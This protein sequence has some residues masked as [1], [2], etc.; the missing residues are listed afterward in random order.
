MEEIRENKGLKG[1][2][3]AVIADEAHSS[4][5][6]QVAAKLKAVLTAEELAGDRG[7]RRDRRRGDPGCGGKRAGS[8]REHLLLRVHRHPQGQ[9][10]GA[11]R[12]RAAAERRSPVPFHVYSMKQAIEEGYIL[13]VLRGYHSFQMAFQ[14]AAERR[15]RR[16]GGPELRPPSAVMRWVKLNPQTIAQKSAI[17]V[18]HFRENVADLLEGHAKAMVVADSRKAAVRYKR[19]IDEYIAAQGLRHTG[20]WSR[21]PGRSATPS[22]GI[23]RRHRSDHEP[24]RRTTCARRSTATRT[25]S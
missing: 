20:R 14:I 8:V 1:K 5:S 7:R 10:A 6:G 25:R 24:R 19:A 21:S 4:Q 22:T 23:E 16:R 18:E 11:V 15:C 17:I 9:D 13:D 3:F 12:P 2:K